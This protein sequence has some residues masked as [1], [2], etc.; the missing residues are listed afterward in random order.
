LQKRLTLFWGCGNLST[1]TDEAN[2]EQEEIDMTNKTK[3][4]YKLVDS[5]V[6]S[7]SCEDAYFSPAEAYADARSTILCAMLPEASEDAL[8]DWFGL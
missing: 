8:L 3:R 6:R 2:T 7:A 1:V 4:I 5:I